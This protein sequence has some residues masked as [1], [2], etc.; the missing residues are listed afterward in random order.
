MYFMFWGILW[1]AL[2]TT[3]R[4]T[5]IFCLSITY[6]LYFEGGHFAFVAFW[7]KF[8]F[9]ALRCSDWYLCCAWCGSCT[10]CALAFDMINLRRI[11]CPEALWH[12]IWSINFVY[13]LSNLVSIFERAAAKCFCLSFGLRKCLVKENYRCCKSFSAVGLTLAR[14]VQYRFGNIFILKNP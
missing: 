1:N 6:S 12:R 8:V 5:R 10:W 11:L 3:R 7:R 4:D 13:F 2:L 9:V 14:Y